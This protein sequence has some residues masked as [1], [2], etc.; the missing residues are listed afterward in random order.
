MS[1][2]RTTPASSQPIGSASALLTL[3][4]SVPDPRRARGIRHQLPGILAVGIA[5]VAAGARSFAAIGQWAADA[6]ENLLAAL[7]S[8]GRCAVGVGDPPHLQPSGRH[9]LGLDPG[10]LAVDPHRRGGPTQGDRPGRQDHPR[11]TDPAPDGSASGRRLR[12]SHRHCARGS[13]PSRRS[14]TRSPP[15]GSCSR[16]S[17]WLARW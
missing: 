10:S 7:G 16:A 2:S 13:L 9:G 4:E 12:P 17:T 14:P 5:A 1:S 11:S 15:S 6:D 8:T 3:L